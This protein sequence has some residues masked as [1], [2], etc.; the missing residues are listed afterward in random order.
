MRFPSLL[1]HR[2]PAAAALAS[3]A[4]L[5]AC[6]GN[7][8]TAPPSSQAPAGTKATLALL[9]TTDLHMNVLSYDY[10][11]LAADNSLGF[12]RVSTLIAQA[13]AQYPNTLLLDNGDT[14]QGTALAD[15]QALVNPVGCDQTLAI[16]KVMNAAKFDGG[17]IGN[18]EFNYGLPYLSQVTGNTFDVDGMPAQQKKC[19][20]PAFPQVLANVISAK[21]NAPL[22]T[23]YTI[24][25]RTITATTPDGKAVSAPVKVG[26]IGFTPPAIMNW[27]KRWLDGKVYT[28]GLKEAAEKY[29][30]E[31]RAKGADL[32]VAISHGGLDNSA[33]SPTMENGSWWLS[34]VPG[35]DAMLI[36]HSHQVFPDANSTVPQFNLPGVDKVKGT[37]NGVPTVMANYWGKHLG[38]IKLGLAF[39]GKTWSVDKSLTTVEARP[40]Q[41]ADKSY[42]AADPSVAAA[43]AA[44]HQATINYVKTPIGSTDY[45]MTSYFADVGDP[46][47]IQIV[48]EAQADYVARYVQANLPQYASLPVLSVSAPFKSGFGGGND[49]TDVAP[50]A[51]AINN[52]ADL[53]LYPNTVY[54]VKV[55]GADVKTWLETAAKRFNRIDPTQATVQKLVSSFPGY[56][57]DMFTSADLSYE[58]DVT[59]PVGSRIRNLT[60]KGAPIDPNG[61]FIVAT[62]NYRASGGGNFPGLDGS[63]TIFASPDANRDVLIAFIKKRGAITRA[64]DGAQRSWRFTKLASSV[65]HVQFASAPNRLADAAAAGLTGI[66][67]VAADDGSGKNLATYEIDLTQ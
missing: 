35:I 21:T 2:A 19:A 26:I 39:D 9:E 48:N 6:N 25:T 55:S 53:Y 34:T 44:E 17:G 38:V 31:M 43:I 36:G 54:A 67:Q 12:E 10:F 14:I 28:T 20:G 18:H 63:K 61:Q 23:P 4:F 37:V 5:A 15:Y 24:L 13:R 7:D 22:F 56:N 41:N 58:I 52:A 45:R 40:I 33:Y 32:I 3:L 57:F 50:G 27:D 49:F 1:R 29:I 46:G 11:K 60:Y 8:V 66:T 51:L 59:Q 47:A 42:V 65:A 64:A 30:P 62:N 16:Y